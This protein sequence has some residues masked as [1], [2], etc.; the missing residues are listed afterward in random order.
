MS[1]ALFGCQTPEARLAAEE[2]KVASVLGDFIAFRKALP[3][4]A[5]ALRTFADDGGYGVRWQQFSKVAF[6]PISATGIRVEFLDTAGVS[7]YRIIFIS[8]R[9]LSPFVPASASADTNGI[10]LLLTDPKAKM[11]LYH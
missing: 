9:G 4:D 2:D 10:T 5:A 3:S 8:A 1:I 11:M 7:D 6:R